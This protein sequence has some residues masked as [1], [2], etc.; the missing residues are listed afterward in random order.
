[1]PEII[2][3]RTWCKSCEDFTLHKWI[4][5][6]SSKA[7]ICKDCKQEENGYSLSEV[8]EEKIKEQRKR[9]KDS[10]INNFKKVIGIVDEM[11]KQN[12][13]LF[14]EPSNSY[15]IVECDAGQ[16][17]IDEL[18]TKKYYEKKKAYQEKV[19]EYNEKFKHL[20]RNDICSCGSQKKYK[21]CHL[22]EFQNL[23][24]SKN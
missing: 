12:S 10:K 18:S 24:I 4:S 23:G 11:N 20:Q 1:M 15:S 2:Y 14:S 8:P 13:H 17:R 9:Y 6:D 3:H 19:D 7:L 21:N 16:K 5:I 22:K